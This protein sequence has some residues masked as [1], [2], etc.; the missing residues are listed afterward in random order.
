LERRAV[1]DR[2]ARDAQR[3]ASKKQLE[4]ED[5]IESVVLSDMRDV[6]DDMAAELEITMNKHAIS[7]WET[8]GRVGRIRLGVAG[9]FTLKNP[10]ILDRIKSR[11]TDLAEIFGEDMADSIIKTIVQGFYVE[12]KNP[13]EVA[14]MLSGTIDG[15]EIGRARAVAR[16]ETGIAVEQAQ[17][18]VYK[19]SGVARKRWISTLDN[20]TRPSHV[21]AHGQVKPID[22]PF[23]VGGNLLMHPLDPDA[24]AEEVVRCRCDEL[25]ELEGVEVVPED[26]WGGE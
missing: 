22:E 19:T 12:G 23:E 17:Y 25:P 11:A 8:G 26:I 9:T 14:R 13:L 20:L 5:L 18:E 15:F 10:M 24:P 7:G 6:F 16:T 3:Q 21:K 4:G 2:F 1:L